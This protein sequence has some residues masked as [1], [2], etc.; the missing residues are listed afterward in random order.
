[1]RAMTTTEYTMATEYM[2]DTSAIINIITGKT[3]YDKYRG[4]HAVTCIFILQELYFILL[5]KFGE[6][7]AERFTD[8]YGI[9]TTDV[10]LRLVKKAM[11]FKFEHSSDRNFSYTDAV[12]YTAALD[13]G[14][15]FLTADKA[16]KGMPNAE[17]VE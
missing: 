16:F 6:Q 7:T 5:K 8:K 17:V 10:D 13:N 15:V 3:A 2:M 14:L 11:R 1:M 9:I 12:A 4:A